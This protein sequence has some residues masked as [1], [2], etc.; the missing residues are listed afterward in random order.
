MHGA[1][2]SRPRN[3]TRSPR[4]HPPTHHSQPPMPAGSRPTGPAAWTP[5]RPRINKAF[6]LLMDGEGNI[7]AGLSPR[8]AVDAPAS[9]EGTSGGEECDASAGAGEVVSPKAPARGLL[10]PRISGSVTRAPREDEWSEFQS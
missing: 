1:N 9:S 4:Q 6:S 5:T 8:A 2:S 7:L 3:S 10:L